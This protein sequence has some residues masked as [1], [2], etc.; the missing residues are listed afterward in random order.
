MGEGKKQPIR[1][2]WDHS[3]SEMGIIPESQRNGNGMGKKITGMGMGMEWRVLGMGMK[4]HSHSDP[5]VAE[6]GRR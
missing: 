1:Q 5:V 4:F 3:H 6:L 2:C